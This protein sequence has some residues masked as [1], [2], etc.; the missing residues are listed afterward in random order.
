MRRRARPAAPSRRQL[1]CLLVASSGLQLAS[2]WS[3][4]YAWQVGALAQGGDVFEGEMTMDVRL[5]SSPSAPL[6]A[7][8]RK[9][10]AG[11]NQMWRWR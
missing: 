5:G 8:F 11:Q 3:H 10:G 1:C 7:S 9:R 4:E 6:L 2:G